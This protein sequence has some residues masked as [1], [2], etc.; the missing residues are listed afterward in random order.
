MIS[1]SL[2]FEFNLNFSNRLVSKKVLKTFTHF[3]ITIINAVSYFRQVQKLDYVI[4]AIIM[5]NINKAFNSKKKIGST[6]IL[7][8]DL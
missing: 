5:Q 7:F 1:V 8:S 2:K 4:D 6:T 3:N